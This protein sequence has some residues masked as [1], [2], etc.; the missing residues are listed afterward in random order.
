MQLV[1][2]DQTQSETIANGHKQS[3]THSYRLWSVMVTVSDSQHLSA[4]DSVCLKSL[5]WL[6]GMAVH[7]FVLICLSW[8]NVYYLD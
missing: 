1:T 3:H 5:T 4:L 6:I 7:M 8:C 2:N